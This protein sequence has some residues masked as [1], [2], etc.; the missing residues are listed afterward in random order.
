MDEATREALRKQSGS[1]CEYCRVPEQYD[2]LPFQ[3]DH[4]IAQKHG[5]DSSAENLAWSCYDCNVFKGPNIAGID[6]HRPGEP[7]P[8][9][10]PR[11]HSWEDHFRSKSGVI[12][13]LTQEGRATV[14][15]LRLNLDRRV[16][17]RRA[18]AQ[19]GQYPLSG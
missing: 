6:P 8:L 14:A 16:A 3:P 10:H 17:F 19:E 7:T 9:F 13:G 4:I 1:F 11:K 18:L 2:R 5:G 12:E 15:T